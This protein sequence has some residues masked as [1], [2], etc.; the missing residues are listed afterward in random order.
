[1]EAVIAPPIM[2][3]DTEGWISLFGSVAEC[4]AEIESPDVEAG[5]YVAFDAEGRILRL[6]VVDVAP[7]D[8]W[9]RRIR[10][11]APVRVVASGRAER[12]DLVA[13][14]LEEALGR[15][16]GTE[17]FRTLLGELARTKD[18]RAPLAASKVRSAVVDESAEDPRA[19]HPFGPVSQE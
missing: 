8:R 5:E 15:D 16:A 14:L 9:W 4:E 10:Y 11:Q 2:V 12:P 13:L 3:V 6:E 17:P 19:R 7:P 1:M 18:R